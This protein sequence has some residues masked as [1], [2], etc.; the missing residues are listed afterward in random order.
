M[1]EVNH[2]FFQCVQARTGKELQKRQWVFSE[3]HRVSLS[4]TKHICTFEHHP[5]YEN[6]RIKFG[7]YRRARIMMIC[8]LGL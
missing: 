6:I 3:A 1:T 4:T 5:A 7:P 8:E 2:N